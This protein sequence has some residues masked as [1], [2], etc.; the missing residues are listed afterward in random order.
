MNISF[1]ANPYEKF[2]ISLTASSDSKFNAAQNTPAPEVKLQEQPET[3][4][5]KVTKK[6]KKKVNPLRIWFNR[7]KPEQIEE[8]NRTRKTP[9]NIKIR[10]DLGNTGYHIYHNI[11]NLKNG[12][13]TLPEGYE[14]RQN[15]LGFTRLVLKDSE[16]FWLRKKEKV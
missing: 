2:G 8:I 7:L 11:F 3:D 5:F 4:V 15:L 14:L 6:G 9:D 12:T 1:Q 10:P 16:G 13:K